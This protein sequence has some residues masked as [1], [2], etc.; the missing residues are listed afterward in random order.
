MK[1]SSTLTY[2]S[3]LILGFILST[4]TLAFAAY[5]VNQF[6]RVI[7]RQYSKMFTASFNH[8]ALPEVEEQWGSMLSFNSV[9]NDQDWYLANISR[10]F[11]GMGYVV[12]KS[13]W[14]K[15][16]LYTEMPDNSIP[17]ISN[18]IVALNLNNTSGKTNAL[19]IILR[20]KRVP[21]RRI[22]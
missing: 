20:D 10:I 6:T 13:N 3:K 21:V 22:Y 5:G 14:T 18:T 4:L 11:S 2:R 1:K 7:S 16:M 15:N 12:E 8:R 17:D 9:K 19:K